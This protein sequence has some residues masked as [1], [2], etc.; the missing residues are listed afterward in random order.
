MRRLLLFVLFALFAANAAPAL[1]AQSR[2]SAELSGQQEVPPVKTDASGDLKLTMY[3][4]AVSFEL[5]VTDL[6]SPIA[7]NLHRGRRGENGPPVAGIF[8]GP[9]KVGSFSG[10]LAEGTITDESLLGEFKGKKVADLVRLIRA[11]NIYVN[12]S[13]G[14]FPDGEIRGQI[15]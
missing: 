15:K 9:A 14:T 12:I 8:G 5:N 10:V 2:F 6:T 11:G 1:A 7:A 4:K 13:T 3:E